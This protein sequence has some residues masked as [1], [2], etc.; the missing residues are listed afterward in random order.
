MEMSSLP[1]PLAR[2]AMSLMPRPVLASA[3]AVVMRRMQS[4]H[5]KLFRNL[6]GL[7][8]ATVHLVPTDLP[9]AFALTLG[10]EPVSFTVHAKTEDVSPSASVTGSLEALV[11][12]LE[13][14]EDGDRLFFARD[15]RIE[16]DTSV[17]VGLRNTLD[18]EEIDLFSDIASLCGPFAGAAKMAVRLADGLARHARERL[19]RVHDEL[20]REEKAA[21]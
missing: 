2:A 15:I 5:P 7:S 21:P 1:I 17:I 11:D 14:R 3:V 19:D 4:R 10:Q 6:A 12:M 9:H 18:R 16:G 8:E 20:H 13:G